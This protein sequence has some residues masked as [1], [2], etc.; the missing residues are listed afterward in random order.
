MFLKH[1]YIKCKQIKSLKIENYRE[2]FKKVSKAIKQTNLQ[3]KQINFNGWQ[4]NKYDFFN[5]KVNQKLLTLK[6]LN[7]VKFK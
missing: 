2:Q 1:N 7:L 4:N 3:Q 5:I 6:V